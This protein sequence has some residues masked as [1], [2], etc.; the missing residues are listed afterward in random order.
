M[1]HAHSRDTPPQPAPAD[2]ATAV[3]PVCGMTVSL[4][5]AETFVYEGTTYAFC[6]AGCRS[7]FEAEPSRYLVVEAP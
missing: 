3:D 5:G 6:C 1:A 2:A 7:R 4:V